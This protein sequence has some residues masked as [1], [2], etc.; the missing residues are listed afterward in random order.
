[1][2]VL[3]GYVPVDL[4]FVKRGGVRMTTLADIQPDLSVTLLEYSVWASSYCQ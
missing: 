3:S 1:M 4:L 2:Y